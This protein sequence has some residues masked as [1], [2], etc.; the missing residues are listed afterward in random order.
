MW[1]NVTTGKKRVPNIYPLLRSHWYSDATIDPALTTTAAP[2]TPPIVVTTAP[3]TTG[4]NDTFP[5][6]RE[7]E[8]DRRREKDRH[9]QGE[10]REG[11]L[12]DS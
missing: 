2:T 12:R 1:L 4:I 8:R 10:R 7:T 3:P 5:V 9:T 11:R 6:M